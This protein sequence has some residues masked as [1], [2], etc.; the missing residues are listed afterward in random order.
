[1]KH[2]FKS[3][4]KIKV[5]SLSVLFLSIL[6]LSCEKEE[7]D[8]LQY[9]WYPTYRISVFDGNSQPLSNVKIRF[10]YT[11]EDDNI[12]HDAYTDSQ[13]VVKI[14]GKQVSTPSGGECPYTIRVYSVSKDGYSINYGG[15]VF[16]GE[17]L[18]DP[19]ENDRIVWVTYYMKPS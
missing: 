16:I 13:G 6:L 1:M 14:E 17:I 4:L 7:D 12:R 2:L 8:T 10:R 3:N 18:D 5:L 11:N 9:S 19:Y 15:A